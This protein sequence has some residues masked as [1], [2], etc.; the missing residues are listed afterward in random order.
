MGII[1]FGVEI[2]LQNG[3]GLMELE[4]VDYFDLL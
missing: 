2:V 3:Y 1:I 4:R